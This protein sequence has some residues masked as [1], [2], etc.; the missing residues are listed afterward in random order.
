MDPRAP[1]LLQEYFKTSKEVIEM[2]LKLLCLSLWESK[3]LN[4]VVNLCTDIFE[5]ENTPKKQNEN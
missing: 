1:Y 3:I 4:V 5:S 2:F